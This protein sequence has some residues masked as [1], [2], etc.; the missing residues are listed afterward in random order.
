MGYIKSPE[1]PEHI[2]PINHENLE[3][4]ENQINTTILHSRVFP[5]KLH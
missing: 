3:K 5:D 2:A 1:L 4:N